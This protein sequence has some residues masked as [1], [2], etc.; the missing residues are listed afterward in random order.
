M[1]VA[2][3]SKVTGFPTSNGIAWQN[4]EGVQGETQTRPDGV[5]QMFFRD[6][7]AIGWRSTTP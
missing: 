3:T 7:D 5:R 2:D 6:P 1:A 4:F